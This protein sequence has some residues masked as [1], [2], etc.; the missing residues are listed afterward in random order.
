VRSA[1]KVK[2]KTAA[3]KNLQ[4]V[5][6]PK[7]AL[8]SSPLQPPGIFTIGLP[9]GKHSVCWWQAGILTSLPV[10]MK[11]LFS[12]A[13]RRAAFFV[14]LGGLW[15]GPACRTRANAIVEEPVPTVGAIPWGI[16]HGP[17]G[18]YWFTE[19][20]A[21][22]IGRIDTNG[23]VTEYGIPSPASAPISITIG[24]DTNLWFAEAGYDHVGRVST[25]TNGVVVTEFPLPFN[26]VE[27]SI[28]MGPDGRLWLLD[29]G[30]NS[31]TGQ[32]TNGGVVAMT[33]TT[34]GITN[35]TYYNTGLTVGSRPFAITSGPDGNL[36]FTESLAGK[37]A[38]I[39]TN[40]V[41]TESPLLPQSSQ[42]EGI[43]TGP[44]G[45]IWFTLAAANELG[46][47][48]IT[49][50]TNFTLYPLPVNAN[51]SGLADAPAD[52]TLGLDGNLYFTDPAGGAIGRVTVRGTNISVFEVFT[53]T[54]NAF[55]EH[56]ATGAGSNIWFTEF[57]DELGGVADNIGELI[58]PAPL[59]LADQSHDEFCAGGQSE[60][61]S[62]QLVH[63]DQC[64]DDQHQYK[65][66]PVFRDA[67][68]HRQPTDEH[69][70]FPVDGLARRL[71]RRISE[72]DF[73]VMR[74]LQSDGT[75][76]A[77]SFRP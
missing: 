45:A 75:S 38:R 19:Y 72:I 73:C 77:T 29:F 44:D 25:N 23:I 49:T 74:T 61:E 37:I 67:A 4:N 62:D 66:Q 65:P 46:R 69:V 63:C 18:A 43:T 16:T 59:S 28:T 5:S 53:P 56:L 31:S 52:I 41:I 15:I 68:C 58:Q 34:N 9:F 70:V 32:T 57:V 22:N 42:P 3:I 36:Y 11:N 10:L 20:E 24:P 12:V 8:R 48:D 6:F 35:A 13:A 51:G 55:P 1:A 50:F 14:A 7:P 2:T 47:L 27:T 17:D 54:T 71:T 39:T 21:G 64:A 30:N 60:P 26:L 33:V 40:G 76:R